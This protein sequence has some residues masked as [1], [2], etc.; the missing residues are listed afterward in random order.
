MYVYDYR[1]STILFFSFLLHL[2]VVRH[3][4]HSKWDYRNTFFIH[5]SILINAL[6]RNYITQT[7]LTNI[8]RNANWFSLRVERAQKLDWLI[9]QPYIHTH[10][11]LNSHY[12]VIFYRFNR[13]R[14]TSSYIP[15]S[16][17]L[18]TFS[19]FVMCLY[20]A[21]ISWRYMYKKVKLDAREIYC[22]NKRN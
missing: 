13:L 4:I 6:T 5:I 11:L 17:R 10:T 14:Y 18:F 1:L 19:C 16:F 21:I 15:F 20:Y 3:A 12:R 8:Y 22:A 2:I 7:Q 9:N